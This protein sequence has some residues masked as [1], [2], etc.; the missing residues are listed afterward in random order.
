[1]EAEKRLSETALLVTGSSRTACFPGVRRGAALA[2][3]ITFKVGACRFGMH[4]RTLLARM[5][6]SIVGSLTPSC[7]AD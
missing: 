1:M 2:V 4:A 6:Q 3:H 5:V 7:A